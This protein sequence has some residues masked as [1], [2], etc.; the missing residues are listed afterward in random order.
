[1]DNTLLM[2]GTKKGLWMAS[3][4]DRSRGGSTARTS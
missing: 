3:S 2:I 4:E 1:M